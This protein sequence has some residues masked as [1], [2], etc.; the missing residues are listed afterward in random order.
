[1]SWGP[2]IFSI[3][4]IAVI[5]TAGARQQIRS[6]RNKTL[7]SWVRNQPVSYSTRAQI[8][9]RGDAGIGWVDLK[10]PFGGAQM[11][12]RTS[13]IELSLAPPVGRYM[14]TGWFLPAEGSTMFVDHIGWGGT[15]I[16]KRECIRLSG[17][18]ANGLVEAAISPSGPIGEAWQALLLAGVQPVERAG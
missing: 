5:V 4:V 16:A 3:A 6:G 9:M 2:L 11:V 10:N 8:R 13:G 14:S 12:V 17:H 7:K 15:P 18:D 1:V